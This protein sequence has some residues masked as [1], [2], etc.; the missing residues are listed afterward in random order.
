MKKV[1]RIGYIH[2]K[3]TAG[4]WCPRW[5]RLGTHDSKHCR[6]SIT[7]TCVA[8]SGRTQKRTLSMACK[9]IQVGLVPIHTQMK[10]KLPKVSD[11]QHS[12]LLAT[13]LTITMEIEI[14]IKSS[15]RQCTTDDRGRLHEDRTPDWC[16][17]RNLQFWERPKAAIRTVAHTF[18]THF[19]PLHLPG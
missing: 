8:G 10:P 16:R 15:D 12:Q 17:S 14:E 1:G 9:P 5:K 6:R 2:E 7:I 3:T 11:L 19:R 4:I 18:L 13:L